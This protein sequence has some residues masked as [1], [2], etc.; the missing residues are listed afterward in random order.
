[1]PQLRDSSSER[2]RDEGEVC[3]GYNSFDR[4]C[5]LET[6]YGL[7]ATGTRRHC[8]ASEAAMAMFRPVVMKARS[9]NTYLEN[10]ARLYLDVGSHPEY[11]TAEARDPM[12]ALKQDL[13]GEAIM[14]NLASSAQQ[15]LRTSYGAGTTVH[16]FKNNADSS[17]HSFGCHENYLVRRY[18]PLSAIKSQLLPFLITRQLFTGAGCVTSD[19][20]EITQRARFVEDGVSSATTRVRPMVNTRDEPHADPNEFRRLHVIIG[21]S[22]RSQWATF[23]KLATTHLVLCVIEE[24]ARTGKRSGLEDCALNNPGAANRALSADLTLHAADM[25]PT[26]ADAFLSGI[27]RFDNATH[28]THHS[29][30]EIHDVN[31]HTTGRKITALEIQYRYWSVASRFVN[32]HRQAMT[33]SLP[34]SDCDEVLADWKMTLDA[35]Q[36]GDLSFLRSKVDWIAKYE[37][38]SELR[39][40][41][42]DISYARLRQLDMDYHDISAGVTY[43]SLCRHGVIHTLVSADAVR[44]SVQTPPNDTRAAL[45]GAFITAANACGGEYACDWTDLKTSRPQRLEAQLIDPFSTEPPADYQRLINSLHVRPSHRS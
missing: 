41:G 44:S 39:N 4:I 2:L 14:R 40:R 3:P 12:D 43:P 29:G 36:S 37:L 28:P 27:D 6:E 34:H 18:V 15:E 23:M 31:H 25:D 26:D 32:T 35:L 7:A 5:G 16:V 33:Q 38:L 8:E 17:G 22:N 45:R 9:T 10:G 24:A 42:S 11:A 30:S 1:M 21:D 13:A 19:G 20:F